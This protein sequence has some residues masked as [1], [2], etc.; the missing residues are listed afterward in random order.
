MGAT[1]GG[2]GFGLGERED[3]DLTKMEAAGKLHIQSLQSEL[4]L[5]NHLPV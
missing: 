2:G 5:H 1:L 3:G 4:Y